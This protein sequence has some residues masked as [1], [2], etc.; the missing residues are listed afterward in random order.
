MKNTDEKTVIITGGNKGIGESITQCFLKA[1]FNVFVG[2]REKT[3]IFYEDHQALTFVQTDVRN[4]SA[5]QQLVRQAMES[6]GRVDVYVNNA[7]LS[8]WK[9]LEA[10]TEDFVDHLVATN[11][12]SVIWGC[13]AAAGVMKPGAAIINISSIAG[14]RGS[15]NNAVYCATKFAVNGIT[16]SLAKE[17][18]P[19]GIRVNALCPV[20]VNTPGL[21]KALA[22]PDAPGGDDPEGFI[23]NFRKG[24]AA[25]GRLP[26]G[27]EVGKFALYLAGQNASAITGQ[28]INVDCGVLPQ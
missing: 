20:L 8:G 4:E 16:Q 23:D 18:G 12:K 5:H 13:K 15:K 14:K 19:R 3:T 1:G 11:L 27:E 25:L 7:G 9:P 6:T 22:D 26:T 10:L 17:L 24:N 21:L 2:A 28:C